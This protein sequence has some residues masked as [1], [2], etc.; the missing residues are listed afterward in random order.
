LAPWKG[1]DTLIHA[2]GQLHD[3]L[4]PPQLVVAGDGEDRGR[5]ERLAADLAPGQVTFLGQLQRS[6]I[7]PLMAQSSVLALASGYEGLSHVLLEGMASGLP[8][9]AADIEGN[10]ELLV[11]GENGWLVR[12]GDA[13][14]FAAAIRA[15]LTSASLAAD[16]GRRNRAWAMAHTVEHQVDATLE[17]CLEAISSRHR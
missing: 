17:V 14:G 5:L 4:P 13:S 10:R 1:I 12:P 11:D 8:I 3:A 2:I 16:F 7:E 9:V 15:C 6:H